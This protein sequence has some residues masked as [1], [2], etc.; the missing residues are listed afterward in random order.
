MVWRDVESVTIN[1][2]IKSL[3]AVI[4]PSTLWLYNYVGSHFFVT[5]AS[6]SVSRLLDFCSN[7][8]EILNNSTMIDCLHTWEIL[9]NSTMIY[10]LNICCSSWGCKY[11][12][13]CFMMK[14]TPCLKRKVQTSC[15]SPQVAHWN[16]N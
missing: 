12:V 2:T 3:V 6:A 9:N 4:H 13:L 15:V 10:Y 8:W 16:W 1:V 14:F 11:L 7:S 5:F